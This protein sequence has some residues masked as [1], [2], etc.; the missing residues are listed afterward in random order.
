MRYPSI[1]SVLYELA[2]TGPSASRTEALRL[3][4]LPDLPAAF[5]KC[6]RRTRESL[7]R[8]LACDGKKSAKARLG[9][10]KECVFG[11]TPQMEEA[12]KKLK[13]TKQ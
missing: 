9:A 1:T 3:L 7:L 11:W 2:T 6:K 8:R 10:L 12:A 13:G 5:P 4:S